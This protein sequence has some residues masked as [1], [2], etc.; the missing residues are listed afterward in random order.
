MKH[1]LSAAFLCVA[2]AA[3]AVDAPVSISGSTTV[4]SAI[5]D[6]HRAAIEEGSGLSLDVIANGSSRGIND[7][8]E[9]RS[10]LAMISAP[11]DVTIAKIEKKN[12]GSVA[13]AGLMAHQV[14]E[15][16]VAFVVHPSNP[17]KSLSLAQIGAVLAGEITTW[18]ELG[19]PNMPI[20]VVA[21][22]SGGGVRSLVESELLDGESIAADLREFP[23][24]TQVPTVV[25]Q[26]PPGLGIA[27]KSAAA[28]ANVVGIETESPVSQ[29]LILVTL[30]EPSPEA[31]RVID[32]ARAAA[33]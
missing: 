5:M 25:S 17:V 29:P 6:P 4:A 33:Q 27:A 22:T 18:A 21:E 16:L 23:N 20:I 19:G 31:Q 9:G 14:G 12:P 1:Y 30:G 10:E 28:A 11:L 8:V 3:F 26:L 13:D 32:A 2:S 15:T 24:A 7:L